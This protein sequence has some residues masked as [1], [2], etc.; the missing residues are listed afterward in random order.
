MQ[1]E[2]S[3]KYYYILIRVLK[4]EKEIILNVGKKVKEL[5]LSK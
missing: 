5:A 1:I 2:T 4:M 3:M